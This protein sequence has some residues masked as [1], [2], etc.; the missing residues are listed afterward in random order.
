ML[1]FTGYKLL[2]PDWRGYLIAGFSLVW[3]ANIY[4]GF[5]SRIRMDIK[6]EKVDIAV[7]EEHLNNGG[8]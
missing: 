4:M 8:T 3:I 6:K 5:F 2:L 7:K 1:F